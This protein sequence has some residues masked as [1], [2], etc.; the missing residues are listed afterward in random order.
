MTPLL[1]LVTAMFFEAR[2]QPITGMEMVAEVIMNR[3]EHP[4]FPDTVCDVVYERKQFSFA[5][6]G[7]ASLYDYQ[8][9][10]DRKAARLA[11]EIALRYLQGDRLGSTSTHYHKVT[12]SPEWKYEFVLDGKVE[13]HIFYTCYENC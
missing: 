13:D 7:Y 1:C 12:V 6:K 11:R 10:D 9:P 5:N 4:S 8:E 2:D 3:V